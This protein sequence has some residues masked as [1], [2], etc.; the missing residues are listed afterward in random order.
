MMDTTDLAA[1]LSNRIVN[2]RY[3]ITG[4]PR[5]GDFAYIYEAEDLIE[6]RRVALKIFKEQQDQEN[7]WRQKFDAEARS[8]INHPNV[9]EILEHGVDDEYN[10]PFIVMEWIDGPTLADWLNDTYTRDIR[11]LLKIALQIAKGLAAIHASGMTHN[12]ITPSNILLAQDNGDYVPKLCDFGFA[13]AMSDGTVKSSTIK[14]AAPERLTKSERLSTDPRSDIYSLGAVLYELFT[15]RYYLDNVS[16][17]DLR[18]AIRE[19]QP[20]TLFEMGQVDIPE[21]DALLQ[22]MLQKN[23]SERPPLT[24]VVERLEAILTEREQGFSLSLPPT[25]ST[26]ELE[27]F[28]D[29]SVQLYLTSAAANR[30]RRHIL[31]K[32]LTE[33]ECANLPDDDQELV[34]QLF[35]RGSPYE[36]YLYNAGKENVDSLIEVRLATDSN[37]EENVRLAK[38][39]GGTLVLDCK[40]TSRP[41]LLVSQVW[42]ESKSGYEYG[43]RAPNGLPVRFTFHARYEPNPASDSAIRALADRVA[44]LP[45]NSQPNPD[46][47]AKLKHWRAYLK[48]WK[49][50]AEE[51]MYRV[52]Y[53]QW[54]EVGDLVWFYLDDKQEIPWE[55][56]DKTRDDQ[57]RLLLPSGSFTDDDLMEGNYDTVY[58]GD[59]KKIDRSGKR[60][61]IALDD[62]F[63]DR[64]RDPQTDLLDIQAPGV[65]I[66]EAIGDL[67]QIQQQERALTRLETGS[68]P[69]PR[70]NRFI[71]DAGR[72][73]LPN[74]EHERIT[75]DE[76][77]ILLSAQTGHALNKRQLQAV[78]GALNAPDL[79]LI[80]GPPG[81]GKTTVIAELCYQFTRRGQRV[82][83]SSQSNLAVDNALSKLAHHPNILALRVGNA[84]RVE[85]EGEPFVEEQVV[86]TWFKRTAEDCRSQLQIIEHDFEQ[87]EELVQGY[88]RLSNYIN[89]KQ[90]YDRQSLCFQKEYKERVQKREEHE[91]ALAEIE[92]EQTALRSYRERLQDIDSLLSQQLLPENDRIPNWRSPALNLYNI[93]PYRNY[94]AYLAEGVKLLGELGVVQVKELLNT[95]LNHYERSLLQQLGE[96]RNAELTPHRVGMFLYLG[97]IVHDLL[98][99][100]TESVEVEDVKELSVLVSRY[101]KARAMLAR[102][103]AVTE[104]DEN[105]RKL[106]E[107]LSGLRDVTDGHAMFMALAAVQQEKEQQYLRT[108]KQYE[109]LVE[110]Q[111]TLDVLLA[112]EPQVESGLASVQHKR[113]ALS[114]RYSKLQECND[115]LAR[116][117]EVLALRRTDVTVKKQAVEI[118]KE[119]IASYNSFA[120]NLEQ[121]YL[122]GIEQWLRGEIATLPTNLPTPIADA[123]KAHT[124]SAEEDET[125]RSLKAACEETQRMI[126][127]CEQILGRSRDELPS[128]RSSD[129]ELRRHLYS[130][131]QQDENDER[132]FWPNH[133]P[134]LSARIRAAVGSRL[135]FAANAGWLRRLWRKRDPRVE[136]YKLLVSFDLWLR[137]Q[138][139]Y[140]RSRAFNDMLSKGEP[141][142][143]VLNAVS[144]L[145]SA[146][147]NELARLEHE[148]Q[149]AAQ[150][151]DEKRKR[152]Q[153]PLEEERDSL[154]SQINKSV[155]ELQ[156]FLQQIDDVLQINL[157]EDLQTI[158]STAQLDSSIG[159]PDLQSLLAFLQ[160]LPDRVREHQQSLKR[161]VSKHRQKLQRAEN[162]LH[163]NRDEVETA[164]DS[165]D[166]QRAVVEQA[167]SKAME[168]LSA[169]QPSSAANR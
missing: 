33:S 83:V 78:E 42:I 6:E 69:N 77:D 122:P 116:A 39:L 158:V 61:A 57:L 31:P 27:P 17:S 48:F 113:E 22:H 156:N 101:Q 44:A 127:E 138:V 163:A 62:D 95:H 169:Y 5:L 52:A 63:R 91:S 76:A 80:Q 108:K 15:H 86:A 137:Q 51:K 147:Q 37:Q 60:L 112:K 68:T 148:Y 117:E 106:R 79:Y 140:H 19:P 46:V 166:K 100:S 92:S 10:L 3:H 55:K 155:A 164:T 159:Q 50:L 94:V 142:D 29:F 126:A 30:I 150:R 161:R 11:L 40:K 115:N 88:Q 45:E 136:T 128:G 105:A 25:A 167:I 102:V 26:V 49:R 84:D 168:L 85:P 67:A 133:P 38:E 82:L 162:D 28:I 109:K 120:T 54:R 132:L 58:I 107:L 124:W 98:R 14:Y 96:D 74:P 151:Y 12:N 123:L 66:Y 114:H 141:R 1:Q 145:I 43:Y 18:D 75:I 73:A 111:H 153:Q 152:L 41:N 65:L 130:L 53:S 7:Y 165:L 20:R 118:Q 4:N 99:N 2:N 47:Q 134:E 104:A 103:E 89:L 35:R 34:Y 131:F 56:I 36:C 16:E 154:I 71:F 21:L 129:K 149:E 24:S 32:L 59:L 143:V 157:T 70:L 119:L 90:N 13:E 110:E 64:H 125:L 93:E 97:L 9:V 135:D 144:N 81:T 160:A 87:F 146:A 72:A 139:Q 23:P 121:Q 8:I